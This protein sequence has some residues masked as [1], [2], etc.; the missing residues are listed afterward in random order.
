MRGHIG[1]DDRPPIFGRNVKRDGSYPRS[2]RKD[3]LLAVAHSMTSWPLFADA[4]R[5]PPSSLTL[6]YPSPNSPTVG[7]VGRALGAAQAAILD[8]EVSQKR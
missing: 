3:G 2:T 4:D 8:S 6:P 7:A 1:P 5:Q